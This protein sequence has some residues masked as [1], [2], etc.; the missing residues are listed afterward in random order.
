MLAEAF[1]ERNLHRGLTRGS[2][3]FVEARTELAVPMTAGVRDHPAR[4]RPDRPR[5]DHHTEPAGPASMPSTARWW[6]DGG[7]VADRQTRH[8]RST[9]VVLRSRRRPRVQRRSG[10]RPPLRSAAHNVW[11]HEDRW[12]A[13][14]GSGRRCEAGGV[15][16]PRDVHRRGVLLRQ[17]RPSVV[18][19]SSDATFFDSHARR[20]GLRWSR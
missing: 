11:N 20:T 14:P 9:A 17:Q 2:K 8:Q 5:R 19:C 12:V 10:R 4:L 13:Q 15:R 16:G 7:G 18:I 1:R 3:A 6:G